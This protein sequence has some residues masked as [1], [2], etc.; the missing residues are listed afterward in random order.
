[1]ATK[2]T[3]V[4]AWLLAVCLAGAVAG[5]A[6]LGRTAARQAA[7]IERLSRENRELREAARTARTAP[8]EQPDPVHPAAPPGEAPAHVPLKSPEDVALIER[9]KAGVAEANSSIA[10][11]ETRVQELQVEGQRLAVDNKRLSASEADLKDNLSSANRLVEAL[12]N[13]LKAKS[14]RV[15]QLEVASRKLRDQSAV[16]SARIAQLGQLSAE[17]QELH[18]RR[19]TLLNGILRRYKEVT[20]QYRGLAG[21]LENRAHAEGPA[22]SGTDVAR[23]QNSIEQAEDDLRQLNALN[24]QAVRLEKKIATR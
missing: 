8:L 3:S 23:I 21:L 18:R 24:A 4:L 5:I 19:E 16:E 13:E 6:Y 9:L 17:W 22:V 15:I 1:M 11:L 12:Q 14:E 20:D 7:G 10:Q 2:R